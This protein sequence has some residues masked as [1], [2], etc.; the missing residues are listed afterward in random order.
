MKTVLSIKRNGKTQLVEVEYNTQTGVVKVTELT[1]DRFTGLQAVMAIYKVLGEEVISFPHGVT[2][3][4]I[5]FDASLDEENGIDA[6]VN[7]YACTYD[8][9]YYNIGTTTIPLWESKK[10]FETY[11]AFA[12]LIAKDYIGNFGEPDFGIE[13]AR[14]STRE[15]LEA[16]GAHFE[17]K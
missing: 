3:I 8:D 15:D 5:I 14:L 9:R 6:R 7:Q 12:N 16:R 1:N 2:S 4:E 13:L 10:S 11:L 17:N